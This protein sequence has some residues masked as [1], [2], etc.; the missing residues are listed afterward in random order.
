VVF[1]TLKFLNMKY[2]IFLAIC[3]LT[4]IFSCKRE[5]VSIYTFED[6]NNK[7][8]LKVINTLPNALALPSS[9]SLSSLAVYYNAN[10]L[11]GT[12]LSYG[13]VFP[14]LEYASVNA[15]TS[16]FF[17]AKILATATTPEKDVTVK[18]LN[19]EAGGIYSAFLLDTVPTA[20]VL[21]IK[22]NLTALVDTA[23][24]VGGYGKYFV[25][26][27]NATPL[28]GG[29]DLFSS[30]D[31]VTP[32]TNIGYKAA[33][34]FIQLDVATGPRAFTVRKTGTTTAIGTLNITPVRGRMYTIFS[35]G[36]EGGTGIRSTRATSYTS[37]FQSPI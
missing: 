36:I 10:K 22:E 13:N 29:Y 5:P 14:S 8:F 23:G 28:S 31:N 17:L 35:Y 2:K 19:L 3:F 30:S 33:S 37:R 9:T 7:A 4:T 27:V 25:R 11:T 24:G 18:T 16:N 1:S 20:D 12:N 21:L 32:I 6:T 34:N 26:L 15:G